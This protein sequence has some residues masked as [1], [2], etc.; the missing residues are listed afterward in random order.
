MNYLHL[1]GI[2]PK[3]YFPFATDDGGNSYLMNV[4]NSP[5]SVWHAYFGS[6]SGLMLVAHTFE[7]F[8]DS[9]LHVTDLPKVDPLFETGEDGLPR[10]MEFPRKSGH[11]V[12]GYARCS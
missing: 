2:V 8:I 6:E 5:G 7:A 1:K 3:G 9:L 12:K 4:A 10:L 11:R